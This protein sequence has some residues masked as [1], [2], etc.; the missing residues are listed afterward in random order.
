MNIGM[1]IGMQDLK[2]LGFGRWLTNGQWNENNSIG[3]LRLCELSL[4]NMWI[5]WEKNWWSWYKHGIGLQNIHYLIYDKL[6]VNNCH[7]KHVCCHKMRKQYYTCL[8]SNLEYWLIK[9]NVLH[10]FQCL[11][12]VMLNLSIMWFVKKEM[13]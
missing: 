3:C 5:T 11:V 7:C 4:K 1:F 13:W 12:I 6:N 9:W 2:H 8:L 10:T